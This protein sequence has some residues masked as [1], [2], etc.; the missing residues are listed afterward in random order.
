VHGPERARVQLPGQDGRDSLTDFYGLPLAGEAH[1]PA[2]ARAV[3]II[4]HG[5]GE[6]RGRYRAAAERF[7]EAGFGTV[8]FDLRGHGE[9][10][11]RR[12]DIGRFETFVDDLRQVVAAVAKENAGRSLFLWGHSMGSLIAFGCAAESPQLLS[13][14]ISTGCP[15]ARF[16]PLM[17]RLS[18]AV[19]PLLRHF[20]GPRVSSRLDGAKL[21]HHEPVI[22][23]YA[24]DPAVVDTVSFRLGLEIARASALTLD[25]A[26]TVH[27]PWLAVHGGQDEI[28]PPA[29]SQ[30][31]IERLGSSDKRLL[32]YDHLR[33][34][35]HN[36][37]PSDAE[38]FYRSC[39]TWIA[40]HTPG[41][42]R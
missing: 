16:S 36:E 25:L 5:L 37:I 11:G 3:L 18:L 14:A 13:G 26:P 6:H 35:V 8:T 15:V 38:L 27:L 10:A 42:D 2:A 28:A 34:E 20:A 30:L 1:I 32:V 19:S 4:V 39:V 40:A 23:A 17:R 21:S 33:H 24:T 22:T 29:G 9:S 12:T 31:L 7:R 41:G